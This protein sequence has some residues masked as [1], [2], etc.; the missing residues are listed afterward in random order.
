M[1]SVHTLRSTHPY[2]SASPAGLSNMGILAGFFG[3]SC[4][5][6]ASTFLVPFAPT[7]FT[8]FFATMAPLIPA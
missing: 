5:I 8:A 7:A 4:G 1:R 6:G 3:A 2:G